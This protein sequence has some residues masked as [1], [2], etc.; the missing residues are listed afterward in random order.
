MIAAKEVD[1]AIKYLEGMLDLAKI[2]RDMIK[3]KK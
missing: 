1:L 2:A 3:E